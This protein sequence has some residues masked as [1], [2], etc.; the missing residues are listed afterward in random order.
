ME[1]IEDN[2]IEEYRDWPAKRV[3]QN[4]SFFVWKMETEVKN[5]SKKLYFLLD[6]F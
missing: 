5:R 3:M 1:K 2:E 4:R 6:L